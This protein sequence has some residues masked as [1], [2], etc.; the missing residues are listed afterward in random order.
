MTKVLAKD[1]F[2]KEFKDGEEITI[3]GWIR[4]IRGSK[5]IGFIEVNDGSFLKNVQV[6]F[7]KD[8]DDFDD[9]K[10]FPISTTIEVTGELALTPDAQQPFEIHATDVKELGSSDVD[11]PL[12][13]KAHTYEY[14]RTI[15]H[16]R[17]R[18]N[19]FYSI[20]RI[21]S[22]AAFAV[23][24]YLQHNGFN[25]I[26]TPIITSSDA[27]GAGEMFQVTTLNMNNV[28]KTDDG[29][30]D[31]NEDFFKKETNLTVSGQLEVEAFALA[32]RNVY[33]FGP[34]FRAENSHTGRH[35]SEFWMIEPE[36]AF[37]DMQD[38]I[39]VSEELLKY[40][41]Q[42]VFDNAKEEIQFLND[43]IDEHL[44]ERLSNTVSEKFAEVT[45]TEAIDLLEKADVDFDV[46]VSWGLDL[47]SEHERY[48]SEKVFKKPVFLTDYPKDIKAFY[49]RANDDG[50]TVAAADL[51]VPEIGEL[52]GGSQRE[53]RLDLL[54]QKIKDLKLNEDEYKWYLELRKYGGT[55]HSGFGIG[56]E[57]LVMYLTGMKNIRDVIAYPRTPG[58]AEF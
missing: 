33:T 40:V 46:P 47:E 24:E 9:I 16:L 53:E 13:K 26:H 21:R 32:L 41:V 43:N 50:K 10:K 25:Y 56:F 45:Y 34:T 48:L 31:Y 23:H 35:A 51:L 15:A 8:L 20:F 38:E 19:T 49:M 1:L 18:T 39:N 36:M 5:K 58:N 27:E 42:Y 54:E 4:T 57:R 29:K 11:Y 12:Q 14:L 3:Q 2:T 6:V 17:P 22:L 28:P 37:A 7:S 30:V 44:I 52:I 55:V